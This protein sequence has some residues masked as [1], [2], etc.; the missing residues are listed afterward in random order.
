MFVG[1]NRSVRESRC[2]NKQVARFAAFAS[3]FPM[4]MQCIFPNIYCNLEYGVHLNVTV[5]SE[6]LSRGA[7]AGFLQFFDTLSFLRKVW[8]QFQFQGN[9]TKFSVWIL[10]FKKKKKTIPTGACPRVGVLTKEYLSGSN[11]MHLSRINY[12]ACQTF[13]NLVSRLFNQQNSSLCIT[14]LSKK[15]KTTRIHS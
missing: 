5:E 10:L 8:D 7:V 13:V 3:F 14:D 1:I 9:G 4:G 12:Y 11:V 2:M 15:K 6:S